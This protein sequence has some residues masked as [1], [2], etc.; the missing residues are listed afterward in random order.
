V[1]QVGASWG[2]PS[3]FAVA[4]ALMMCPALVAVAWLNRMLGAITTT[5]GIGASLSQTVCGSIVHHVSSRA[6]FLFLAGVAV[7]A[8]GIL[9]LFM[10]ETRNTLSLEATP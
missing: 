3:P 6:G 4:N 7:V 2:S 9:Y 5:V 8:R 1:L 10:P